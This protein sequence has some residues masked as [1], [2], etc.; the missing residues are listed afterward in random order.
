MIYVAARGWVDRVLRWNGV[1]ARAVVLPA[2]IPAMLT[3]MFEANPI[4]FGVA[5]TWFVAWC[6]FVAWR[7]SIYMREVSTEADRHYD[8]IGK[9]QLASEYHE[10]ESATSARGR[11]TKNG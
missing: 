10:T 9:F 7:Y 4:M 8:Q 5:T 6:A 1:R 11:K 2:L 3:A